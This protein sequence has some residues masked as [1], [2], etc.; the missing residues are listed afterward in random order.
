MNR[1]ARCLCVLVFVLLSGGM[2]AQ[3]AYDYFFIEAEKSQ[4]AEDYASAMELYRHCLDINPDGAAAIHGLGVLYTYVF[5][6]DSVGT[7]MLRRA[8]ELDNHNPWYLETLASVYLDRRNVDDAVP[9]LEQLSSIQPRRTDVLSHLASLYKSSGQFEKAIDVLNRIEVQ[10]GMSAQLSLEKFSLYK[11]KEEL[12]SAFMEL[13]KLCD[14]FPHDMNYKVLMANQYQ[15][16]DE[17]EKAEEIYSVVRKKAPSNVNLQLA[18]L[19]LLERTGQH[20][21]YRLLRDSLMYDASCGSELRV[22]LLRSCI[23]EAQRDTSLLPNVDEAFDKLLSMPQKDVSLLTLK[24]A[25][26][27]F[28]NAGEDKQAETMR[29]ILEVEPDNEF[30]LSRLLIYYSKRMDSPALED[31]CR[32]GVNYHPEQ[33]LYAF[34]LGIVL[35]QQDKDS[36]AMEVFRHGLQ[37]K[38]E[39]A[40]DVV[41]S[42][43]FAALG[44]IYH[45]FDM[46]KEAYEAYD[47]AL[48]YVEDNISCLNN[49]AYFLFLDGDRLDRAEEMSYRT[50]KAE[51]DNITYLDTYAMI[52]FAKKDYAGARIYMDRV[53]HPEWSDEEILEKTDIKGTLI[54]HAGDIYVMYGDTARALRYWQLAASLGDD[55]CSPQLKKKIKQKKYI[56]SK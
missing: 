4:M 50:I 39:D 35:M 10:E 40:D 47:S 26:Q 28:V 42:D 30:A 14:E 24:V 1:L 43:M 12:D 49:Y 38:P 23:E 8:C 27:A 52:L 3:S 2:K 55:T 29:R 5:P 13:Q 53:I 18:R 41:V 22:Y 20:E 11:G 51:P 6:K 31:I 16:A 48:V 15:A 9:V 44:D 7:T 56:N 37:T 36:E 45:Q 33:L 46:K 25:Y 32:R 17:L 21:Q 54:E 19:D 34:Y